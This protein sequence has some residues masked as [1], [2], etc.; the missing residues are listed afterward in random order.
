M[1][2]GWLEKIENFPKC[3]VLDSCFPK[4]NSNQRQNDFVIHSQLSIG[5]RGTAGHSA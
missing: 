3:D 5:L 4:G 1:S 2:D